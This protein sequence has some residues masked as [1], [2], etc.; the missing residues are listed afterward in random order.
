MSYKLEV[1][2]PHIQNMCVCAY[3]GKCWLSKPTYVHDRRVGLSFFFCS[4]SGVVGE[5]W[6]PTRRED[7][8]L[9]ENFLIRTQRDMD[10]ET[11]WFAFTLVAQIDTRSHQ[12][13]ERAL[14]YTFSAFGAGEPFEQS[15]AAAAGGRESGWMDG[16]NKG[17]R[18]PQ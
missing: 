17:N 3:Y 16:S 9:R 12:K 7:R 1:T 5:S 8:C 2:C 18:F 15:A 14:R 13:R 6:E 10:G 4:S 11:G